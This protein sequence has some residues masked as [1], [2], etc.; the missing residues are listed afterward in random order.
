MEEDGGSYLKLK[1]RKSIV[2][3]IT[4]KK[5]IE[6]PFKLLVGKNIAQKI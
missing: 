3:C 4:G 2:A 5:K 6:N 1:I